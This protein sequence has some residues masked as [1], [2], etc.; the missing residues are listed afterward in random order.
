MRRFALIMLLLSLSVIVAPSIAVATEPAAGRIRVLLTYG[1]H[2]FEEKPFF[3]MFDALPGV[4]YTKAPM[5][6][7]ADLLKPSLRKDYDVVVMYDMTPGF[8]PEQ[9]KGFVQLLNAG[10]GLVSLHHNIGSH[11]E[12]E[13]FRKII[14][15]IHIP[16]VFVVDGKKFGPSGATDDQDIPVTVVDKQHPITKGVNDFLIHDETY[17]K[18]Y[19]APD[20]K[21]LLT[22]DHPKNEPPL[23]WVKQYGQS[24]VFYFMLGHGPT[25]WTNPNY[26]RILANGIRWVSEK[27][28]K[29]RVAS[30]LGDG[31]SQESDMEFAAAVRRIHERGGRFDFD[32]S[33]D[34]VA[35]DLASDRV[36]VSDADLASLLALPHLKRLKLSGS[37]I[38]NAGVR[39]VSS[40]AGL[41]Q[42]SLLDAQ[43]D[44][45]GLEQLVRL[46]NLA[47]LSIRRSPA[48]TDKG[49]E[50]LKR[51]P[52]LVELGLLDLGIT[53]RG[54]EQIA[55]LTGLRSLD[56]RGDA[57]LS[58]AG[59]EQ[60]LALKNLKTLRLGGYQINDDTL[61]VVKGFTSLTSLTIDDAA[62]TDAGLTRIAGLPLREITFCRCFSITDEAFQ[63]LG[64]FSKLRQ[65]VLQ[66]IPLTGSGMQHLRNKN[67]LASLR[68]NE[69]G[70]EDAA[71]QPL[72]GLKNLTRLELHQTQ[73]TDAAVDVLATL[74]GLRVLDIGQ[75]GITDAGAER[76][77]KA[78]PGCK[79][80]R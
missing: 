39:Q 19:T 48:L 53:D 68:L 59:L 55:A 63:L 71:L 76:L 61:S 46:T 23:A 7:A 50:P 3:A 43:I 79:I 31:E 60:L 65:L 66:G 69:T 70:I 1:G 74:T 32:G 80:A 27:S 21:V 25:A 47:S 73:I 35:V 34:L 8:T 13:E 75:T 67:K 38:T 17:H 24:R 57:Q 41:T 10:I 28:E 54:L 77:A 11:Q 62:I 15:G 36:S 56:L 33:G 49:L 45:A 20:V 42:L 78:L 37:G 14:G 9:Q 16:R 29:T 58:N 18:Y 30:I 4:V 6:K 64:G 72:R 26:P 52:K 22:T 2:G 5:P 51:L 44:D 40:L 12:W